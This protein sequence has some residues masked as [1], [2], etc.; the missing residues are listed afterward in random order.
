MKEDPKDAYRAD[1]DFFVLV[2]QSRVIAVAMKVLGIKDKDSSPT[3][4]PMA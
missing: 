3:E 4:C 1:R 2:I